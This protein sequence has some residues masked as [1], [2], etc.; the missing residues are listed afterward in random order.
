MFAFSK[1]RFRTMSSQWVDSCKFTFFPVYGN[2]LLWSVLDFALIEPLFCKYFLPV[3]GLLSHSLDQGFF[4]FFSLVSEIWLWYVLWVYSFAR[5]HST[6][7]ICRVSSLP[8][9]ESFQPLLPWALFQSC[10]FSA[11]SGNILWMLEL[12]LHFHR[13]MKL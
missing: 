4:F 11:P 12:L 13:S 1:Y 3:C 9:L 5:V 7:W 2:F 6:L 10:L 8:D